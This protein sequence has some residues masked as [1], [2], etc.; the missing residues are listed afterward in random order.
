MRS[1]FSGFDPY[2]EDPAIW[3]DFRS[4]FITECAEML[5]E[6]LPPDYDARMAEHRWT[7]E[8]TI[9][10]GHLI[11]GRQIARCTTEM[12]D[13]WINVLHGPDRSLV[14][15]VELLCPSHKSRAGCREYLAKRHGVLEQQVNLVEIDLL[16]AGDRV[17]ILPPP[18]HADY[19]VFVARGDR[20]PYAD[21][22]A[23]SVRD[24]LPTIPIPLRPPD[25]D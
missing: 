22:Y 5:L 6:R 25:A 8:E 14:A 15:V 1:P 12:R 17:P 24:P 21:V 20:T 16:K 19:Y 10:D 11:R 2:L 23:W 7:V 18:P 3:L 4:S 9:D 13:L